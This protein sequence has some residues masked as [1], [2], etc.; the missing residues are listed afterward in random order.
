MQNKYKIDGQTLIVYNRKDNRQMFFS[1]QDADMVKQ[2]TW[3][4]SNGYARTNINDAT[5]K[6]TVLYAHRALLN[7]SKEMQIDH[8]NGVRYDNRRSNLRMVTSQENNHNQRAAKGYTWDKT[9]RRYKA[10]IVLN[11]KI[12]YLGYY[13]TEAEARAAYLEAKKIYHPTSPI[14]N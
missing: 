8:M 3:N 4:I 9:R 12:I 2:Y 5:G 7:P 11:K 14:Q 6:R 1:I 13:N 10:Q